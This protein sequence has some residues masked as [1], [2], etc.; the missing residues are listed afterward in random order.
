MVRV[1]VSAARPAI[2]DRAGVPRPPHSRRFDSLYATFVFQLLAQ[3]RDHP[4]GCCHQLA[5]Q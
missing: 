1:D 3:A 5:S 4:S 2:N